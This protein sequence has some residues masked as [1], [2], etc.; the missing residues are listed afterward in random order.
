M[1]HL[2][3]INEGER[4]T[5]RKLPRRMTGIVDLRLSTADGTQSTE[6]LPIL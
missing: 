6:L 1:A 4:N 2:V 5:G 3:L